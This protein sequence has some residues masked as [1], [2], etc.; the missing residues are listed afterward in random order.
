MRSDIVRSRH[1]FY[2]ESNLHADAEICYEFLGA[3][4][5]GFVHQVLTFQRVRDDSLTAYSRRINTYHAGWL[6]ALVTYGPRYLTDEDFKRMLRQ[7]LRDYYKFLGEEVYRRNGREFWE[8][9]RGKLA[10]VG[11][12][13]SRLRLAAAATSHFLDIALNFKSTAERIGRRVRRMLFGHPR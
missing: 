2:N 7:R 1:S 8:Y 3:H 12:P 13:L 10:A 9:H 4:D 6:H 11:H 5:F